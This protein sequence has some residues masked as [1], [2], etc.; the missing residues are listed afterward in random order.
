[1]NIVGCIRENELS[2]RKCV[3]VYSVNNCIVMWSTLCNAT[4]CK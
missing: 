4:L 1:M 2:V 3:N